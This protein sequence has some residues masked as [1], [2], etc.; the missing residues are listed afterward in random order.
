MKA[1]T[2]SNKMIKTLAK[3]SKDYSVVSVLIQHYNPSITRSTRSNRIRN[4]L[5]IKNTHW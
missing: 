1:K 3:I 5:Y 2:I 4:R